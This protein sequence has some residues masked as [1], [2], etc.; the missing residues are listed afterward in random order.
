MQH[1]LKLEEMIREVK[2]KIDTVEAFQRNADSSNNPTKAT[3][4]LSTS[5]TITI[6]PANEIVLDESMISVENDIPEN[7]LE[8]SHLN[9]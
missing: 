6:G 1:V 4:N 3:Q 5:Q 2:N 7:P 9:L 8:T